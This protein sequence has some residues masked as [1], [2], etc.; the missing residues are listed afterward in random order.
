MKL[1]V[2]YWSEK[3]NKVKST[4]EYTFES[5]DEEVIEQIEKRISE[6]YEDNSACS[7]INWKVL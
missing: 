5:I 6:M 4:T 7:I 3:D 2:A 1:F